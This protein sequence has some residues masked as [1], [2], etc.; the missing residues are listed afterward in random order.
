MGVG[1]GVPEMSLLCVLTKDVL[2]GTTIVAVSALNNAMSMQRC[3]DILPVV[4]K[5]H[6][7][8]VHTLNS[9]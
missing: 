7:F 5:V 9:I 1:R 3:K 6:D 2:E 4:H 8:V